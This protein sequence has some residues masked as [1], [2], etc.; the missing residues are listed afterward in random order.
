MPVR[1]ISGALSKSGRQRIGNVTKVRGYS[2]PAPVGGLNARDSL[3]AMKETDAIQM[4]N[5]YP[6]PSYCEVR[7]GHSEHATG[8]TDP[9]ET[10][11]SWRGLS[12]AK[13]FAAADDSIFDVTGGGAV[14]AA[15]VTSL[16]N[17]RWQHVLYSTSAATYLY[18]VNGA[19]APRHY[20][21][22]AWA[23]PSLTG[24]GLTVANLI[25]VHA[26]KRRLFFVEKGTLNAWYL[27]VDSIAG[28]LTKIDLGPHCLRGGYLMAMGTLTLD[29]GDG[30]D[31]LAVFVTSQGEVLIFSGTDP[32]SANSWQ[33]SGRYEIGVPIG[34]RCLL[35][36]GGDLI[37]L[38]VDGFQLMSRYIISNRDDRSASLSD[39]IEHAVG[40]VA[41]T[42]QSNFGWQAIHYPKG[43]W[44]LFNVPQSTSGSD[45]FQYVMNPTTGA[46][47]RF[48]GM[49]ANCW[50]IHEDS[51]Y[52]GGDTAVY[53]ADDGLSD[54]GDN[55]QTV[56]R[57][58][59]SYFGAR[60]AR[61]KFNMVRP[62]LATDGA[63]NVAVRVNV[64]FED[65]DPTTTSSF[66]PS[67]G[68]TWDV[69][70][71]DVT[72]WATTET[73]SKRWLTTFGLGD[74]ATLKM[75]ADLKNG[76]LKWL[77]TDWKV[78]PVGGPGYI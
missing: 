67:D 41:R 39:K 21:G 23:S 78:E 74:N 62:V 5:W 33:I 40:E 26:F 34:R 49:D 58:A 6:A 50:E 25:H 45:A 63:V 8:L 27:P 37:I 60:G 29:G 4:D 65:K 15:A 9:V 69:A 3:D 20:N 66:T 11:M 19:D 38:T 61:K 57:P 16:T 71:W 7:R 77:S 46:W 44:L 51:L 43:S 24:S 17:A 54:N 68:G 12:S 30:V 13:L 48:T 42:Y 22:S 35:K 72:P 2:V 53:K 47:C 55:I 32:S 73:I 75:V 1:A 10:L 56:V 52:F 64:D 70:L 31:D 14:G 28:T 59:F 76:T 18:I 36:W